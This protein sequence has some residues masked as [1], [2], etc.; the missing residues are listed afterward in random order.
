MGEPNDLDTD[1]VCTVLLS[2]LVARVR[3][4]RTELS[5]LALHCHDGSERVDRSVGSLSS[6]VTFWTDANRPF[7]N[8]LWL[9]GVLAGRV[10]FKPTPGM[11][12]TGCR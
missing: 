5:D 9:L 2:A 7:A 6:L 4:G 8:C 12:K 11:A 3:G 10:K 1:R